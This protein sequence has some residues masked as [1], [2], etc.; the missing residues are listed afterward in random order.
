MSLLN[1]ARSC[2]CGIVLMSILL[3]GGA[4]GPAHAG[5]EKV[6]PAL[7]AELNTLPGT[8]TRAV[9]VQYYG[10]VQ[11]QV[12]RNPRTR[13]TASTQSLL[14]GLV[15][16]VVTVVGGVVGV[17]VDLVNGV[18]ATLSLTE[19]RRLA[20][21][22]NVKFICIDRPVKQSVELTGVATGAYSVYQGAVAKRSFSGAGV[23]VAVLDSGI[24][25]HS[26]LLTSGSLFNTSRVV[27]FVDLVNGK[28]ATYDDNGHGTHVAG[29]IAGN[30]ATSESGRGQGPGS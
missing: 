2:R 4:M 12:V 20:D 26:D 30:G 28:T 16:G 29:A 18:A 14:G 21:D 24:A 13:H 11:T 22:P 10:A 3:L 15:G 7:R 17:L 6:E 25:P 19:V 5:L 23:T 9:I 8:T 27:A 1:W